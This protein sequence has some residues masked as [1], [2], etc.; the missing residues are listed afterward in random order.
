MNFKKFFLLPIVGIAVFSMLG[1][2]PVWAGGEYNTLAEAQRCVA[3]VPL[4]DEIVIQEPGAN[5]PPE[6]ARFLGIRSGNWNGA[7]CGATVVTSVDVDGNA[8][9][10]YAWDPAWKGSDNP[11]SLNGKIKNGEL[12]IRL[13]GQTEVTYKFLDSGELEGTYYR[14]GKWTIRLHDVAR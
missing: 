14:N 10:I 2:S 1:N 9:V 6:T 8:S 5:V 12:T 7:G 11:L 13:R 4:P 3:V